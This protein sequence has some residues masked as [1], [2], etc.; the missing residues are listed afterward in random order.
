MIQ[1]DIVWY[2]CFRFTYS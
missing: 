2:W 1:Y